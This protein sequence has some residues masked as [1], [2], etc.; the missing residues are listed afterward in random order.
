[1]KRNTV[2]LIF[3]ACCIASFLVEI[4][5]TSKAKKVAKEVAKSYISFAC[6]AAIGRKLNKSHS[7]RWFPIWLIV[8]L[9][10]G[11]LLGLVFAV[12]L[13]FYCRVFQ[14][15]NCRKPDMV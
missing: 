3:L 13:C 1:M 15:L 9:V 14:S 4:V 5:E 12:F 7:R 6:K 10:L 11:G 8:V 2:I